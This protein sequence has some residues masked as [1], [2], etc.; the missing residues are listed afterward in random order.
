MRESVC[1]CMDVCGEGMEVIKIEKKLKSW[2]CLWLKKKGE[3]EY[4]VPKR[5]TTKETYNRRKM[6]TIWL[7][8][9][10]ILKTRMCETSYDNIYS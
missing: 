7:K 3:K 4:I 1:M 8:L 5:I 9:A 6:H 2:D 10:P